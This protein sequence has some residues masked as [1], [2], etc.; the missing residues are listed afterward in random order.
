MP[1]GDYFIIFSLFCLPIQDRH[2]FKTD[3][4]S[5]LTPGTLADVPDVPSHTSLQTTMV[6][7]DY[8]ATPFRSSLQG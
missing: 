4:I 1:L 3:T 5:R 2:H 7:L 6:K 8:D